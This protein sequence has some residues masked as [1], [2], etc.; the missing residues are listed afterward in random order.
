MPIHES[1]IKFVADNHSVMLRDDGRLLVWGDNMFGQLGLG[2]DAPNTVYEPTE[3]TYFKDMSATISD[4]AVCEDATFILLSNAELYSFGKGTNGRLGLGHEVNARTPTLVAGSQ[5]LRF[6]KIHTGKEFVIAE[7]DNNE[8][9]AWGRNN[10]GQLGTG[11]KVD[12]NAPV[13]IMESANVKQLCLGEDFVTL[14]KTDNTYWVWGNNEGGRYGFDTSPVALSNYNISCSLG[15]CGNTR[16]SNNNFQYINGDIGG[17]SI[18]A[19][20]K[21]LGVKID[22]KASPCKIMTGAGRDIGNILTS[23]DSGG[24]FFTSNTNTV[25]YRKTASVLHN[26]GNA[27][28][29]SALTATWQYVLPNAF[30]YFDTG[31]LYDLQTGN[32]HGFVKIDGTYYGWGANAVKQQGVNGNDNGYMV[33]LTQLNTF[34]QNLDDTG[35][36]FNSLTVAGDTC[37]ILSS[38]GKV[39]AFGSNTSGKAGLGS[40]L[41]TDAPTLITALAGKGIA[42]IVAGRNTAFYIAHDGSIYVSGDNLSGQTGLGTD[43][44]SNAKITIPML[45]DA[46]LFNR[47]P[48]EISGEDADLGDVTATGLVYACTIT[49]SKD[50]YISVAATV[51]GKTVQTASVANGAEYVFECIGDDWLKLLNGSNQK[52]VISAADSYGEAA[53]RTLTFT[54]NQTEIEFTLA[55]PKESAEKPYRMALS[56]SAQLSPAGCEVLIEAC[57]NAFD[58]IP[59]WEDITGAAMNKRAHVFENAV[60]VAEQWGVDLRVSIKRGSALGDCYVSGF[61]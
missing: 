19:T 59:A 1:I 3:L 45:I 50:E 40:E 54:K 23:Q 13:K 28:H 5:A 10:K 16:L 2:A 29:D 6:S 43:E 22:D 42:N 8:L 55:Q 44:A 4:I 38:D 33:P 49:H 53:E 58:S 12:V 46:S 35:G 30:A 24:A 61:T 37:Y 15:S 27:V 51:N 60:C 14:L 32:R 26:T 39:Y 31:K 18:F 36:G 41:F 57:N 25:T 48:P 20:A 56:L 7:T 34:I 21:N 52:L 17:W 11:D 9:Y 47:Q